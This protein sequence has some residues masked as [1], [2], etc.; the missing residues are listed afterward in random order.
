MAKTADSETHIASIDPTTL[1]TITGGRFLW[2]GVG[3]GQH[4][5]GV[6]PRLNGSFGRALAGGGGGGGGGCA[7]GNCGQ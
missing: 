2:A 3:R 7:G 6:F 5:G 1:E 4:F